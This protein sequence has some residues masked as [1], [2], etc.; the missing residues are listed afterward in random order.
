MKVFVKGIAF[1][2]MGAAFAAE[3]IISLVG[4]KKS[5]YVVTPNT[6]ILARAKN[7]AFYDVLSGA[8][9]VLCDGIGVCALAL[10]RGKIL[11]RATGIDTAQILLKKC[12][13]HEVSVF[14]YGAKEEILQKARQNLELCYQGLRIVGACNGFVS[15]ELAVKLIN[16]SCAKI[17]FVCTSSPKQEF[18]AQKAAMEDGGRVYLALGGVL[19]IFSGQKKRAPKIL[20]RL[21]LEWSYRFI[22]E[23]VRIKRFI[24]NVFGT[25][26]LP[27]NS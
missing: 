21:G 6:E 17:V 10:M 7:K 24:K 25:K 19:D 13:E 20:Q 5:A 16:D 11:K 3:T 15:E 18:F 4:R 14:L 26:N 2:R 23:P 1:D 12:A 22:C 27:N 8:D 9:V